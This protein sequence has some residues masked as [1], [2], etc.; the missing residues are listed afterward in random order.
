[1]RCNEFIETYSD[2]HDGLVSGELGT[3]FERHLEECVSCARYHRVLKRGVGMWRNLPGPSPSRDFLPRLQHRMYHIDDATRLTTRRS[4][5]SAAL[6]AVA[7]VGLLAVTWLPFA[8]RM[9]VEIEL[10]A[11]AVD[12]PAPAA[13]GRQPGLF[14]KGP[15][16][17]STRFLAQIQA[18]LDESNDLFGGYSLTI[19]SGIAVPMGVPVSG[20]LDESR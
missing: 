7:S 8:T 16:V 1:M 18:T 6:V 20:Q 4:L 9:A 19:G 2:Y 10:P 12:V 13:E 3:R 5:G 17:S 14:D 15:Y 11:V